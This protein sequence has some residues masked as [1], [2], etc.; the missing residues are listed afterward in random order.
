MQVLVAFLGFFCCCM[1][2]EIQNLVAWMRINVPPT[3]R[4]L[5]SVPVVWIWVLLS[6]KEC[7]QWGFSGCL[8]RD[9]LQWNSPSLPFNRFKD[10]HRL[11]DSGGPLVVAVVVV[12]VLCLVLIPGISGCLLTSVRAAAGWAAVITDSD[13]LSFTHQGK[14]VAYIMLAAASLFKAHWC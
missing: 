14:S 7:F 4:G 8:Y 11:L 1:C 3:D 5:L 2:S 6:C 10:A 12:A 13:K 9:G